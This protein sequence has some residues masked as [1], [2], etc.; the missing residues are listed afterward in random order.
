MQHPTYSQPQGGTRQSSNLAVA[1]AL[2][3]AGI[4]VFPAI[5]TWNPKT[6]KLDKVPAI[7][8]W[9]TKATTDPAHIERWWESFPD[10][11]PGIEL[12]RAGLVV[13][14]LDRHPGAPDGV[15]A[16]KR[17]R[18]GQDPIPPTPATKTATNGFH[19]YFRQP[20]GKALGNGRGDLPG[21]IDIRGSGGWAVAPG[22][23]TPWGTWLSAQKAPALTVGVATGTLP[24]IPM[25]LIKM[26]KPPIIT[27][28]NT[29]KTT[30]LMA[31]STRITSSREA[32]WASSALEGSVATLANMR[33]GTRNHALNATAYRLARMAAS[34]WLNAS[35]IVQQLFEAC[36]ANGLVNDDGAPSVRKTIISGL[37]KGLTRP[38]PNLRER[39]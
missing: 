6:K 2:A 26:I 24:I 32:A 38:R 22:A 5:V 7:K 9:R 19:I 10:A 28:A 34:G 29:T 27:N 39:E 30:V 8:G 37:T 16:F 12:G 3:S 35:D 18:A 25:W 14:D 11:V 1:K 36:V 17:L 33:P 13:L 20:A 31:T 4:P 23:V 21:G 15:M